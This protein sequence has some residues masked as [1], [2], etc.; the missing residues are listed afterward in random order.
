MKNV[1][2]VYDPRIIFGKIKLSFNKTT[3][4]IET[5]KPMP[6][7]GVMMNTE[8]NEHRYLYSKEISLTETLQ[9]IKNQL[10][11]IDFQSLFSVK[12]EFT[13]RKYSSLEIGWGDFSGVSLVV[14]GIECCTSKE[15]I[16]LH[17]LMQS[18]F[19]EIRME[20]WY[21]VEK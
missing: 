21:A 5:N 3:L 18:L 16:R 1:T 19:K 12:Q 13:G 15:A 2:L 11:Y 14:S 8:T 17:E 7:H 4:V 6:L 9:S 20:E 10:Q